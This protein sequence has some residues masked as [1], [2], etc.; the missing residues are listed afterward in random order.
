MKCNDILV[1]QHAGYTDD[2]IYI[3]IIVI[4]KIYNC[5]WCETRFIKNKYQYDIVTM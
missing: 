2:D 5:K 1:S 4:D 3:P